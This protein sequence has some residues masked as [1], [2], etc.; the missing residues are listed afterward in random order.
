[1]SNSKKLRRGEWIEN[2]EIQK[3]FV[4]IWK[5]Y[6]DWEKRRKGEDGWLVKELKKHNC[7]KIFDSSLGDGCDSIYLIKNGFDVASNDID[8]LIIQKAFE[9]AKKENVQ[10]NI[11]NLD[12]RELTKEIPEQS[13][14]AV[15]CLGN[16]LTSLLRPKDQIAVLKQFY[17]ILKDRGILIIDER[18]YQYILDNRDKVLKGDYRY[19]GKYLYCNKCVRSRWIQIEDNKVKYEIYD[20]RTNERAFFTLYPFKRGE[21]RKFLE[22]A[23]FQKIEQ[24]SDYQPGDNPKADFY[25]YVCQR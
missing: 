20:E 4:K 11:T 5:D 12:W 3:F 18:N 7:Q 13:F 6:I 2:E 23:G 15:L 24:Y 8:E 1:M 19:S 17:A 9:N 22:K 14:D 21:L 25:F 10:L 16:S